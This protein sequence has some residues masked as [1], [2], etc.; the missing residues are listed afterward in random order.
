MYKNVLLVLLKFKKKV[1]LQHC[2]ILTIYWQQQIA[3]FIENIGKLLF[4]FIQI[5]DVVVYKKSYHSSKSINK[6]F[7]R[8]Q[9]KQGTTILTKTGL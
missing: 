6:L 5:L 7:L 8:K 3:Y 1:K 9:E 2:F 4:S